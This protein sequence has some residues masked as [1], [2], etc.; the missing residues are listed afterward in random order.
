MLF[1][2]IAVPEIFYLIRIALCIESLTPY[3]SIRTVQ[4]GKKSK[5]LKLGRSVCLVELLS[6]YVSG[7]K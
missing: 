2:S 1:S 4:N 7:T 3:I 6:Y 5:I